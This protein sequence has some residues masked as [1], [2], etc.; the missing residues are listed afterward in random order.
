[1]NVCEPFFGGGPFSPNFCTVILD[2]LKTG[3]RPG[4]DQVPAILV[5]L[6][7]MSMELYLTLNVSF[8]YFAGEFMPMISD[9]TALAFKLFFF[10]LIELMEFFRIEPC[11]LLTTESG[12]VN[13]T[14]DSY[15]SS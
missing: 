15:S 14:V 1:M 12:S 10:L 4:C 2:V 13:L 7:L 5:L 11:F 8:F 6:F 3:L 9:P